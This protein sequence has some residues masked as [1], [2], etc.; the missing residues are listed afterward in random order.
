M[1]HKGIDMGNIRSVECE[2]CKASLCEWKHEDLYT[3]CPL[4]GCK[5]LNRAEWGEFRFARP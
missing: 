4:C 2:E 5:E 3:E 1:D